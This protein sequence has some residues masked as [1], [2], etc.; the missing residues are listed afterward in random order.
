MKKVNLD[1]VCYVYWIH[2]PEHTDI[3][4]E[5]YV[6]ITNNPKRRFNDHHKIRDKRRQIHINNAIDKYGWDNLV[7]DIILMSTRRYCLEIE[8]KLRPDIQVGW[9][10]EKGGKYSRSGVPMSEETRE[11]NR[12]NMKR[13]HAEE[14]ERF[15]LKGQSKR[16]IMDESVCFRSTVEAAEFLGNKPSHRPQIGRCCNGA[17]HTM[18]VEGHVF[19]FIDSDKEEFYKHREYLNSLT[20]EG[21]KRTAKFF[22]KKVI[23]DGEII[24]NSMTEVHRYL[25]GEHV[26]GSG[27][28]GEA[29]RSGKLVR[30]H[31]VELYEEES[32]TS[33]AGDGMES[34][35]FG[36]SNQV[37]EDAANLNTENAS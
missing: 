33:R 24:F 26:K 7:K 30:G 27:P 29:V 37:D 36:T 4:T 35:G 12:Q 6:G 23:L 9:N 32:N 21:R 31:T 11:Y 25:Y 18:Y 22:S 17:R 10:I 34:A 3:F 5:G 16:V 1:S 15:N 20:K 14:P 2:L 19:R 13:M 28:I 8:R